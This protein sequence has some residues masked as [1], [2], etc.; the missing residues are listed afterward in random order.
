MRNTNKSL[1]GDIGI[2]AEMGCGPQRLAGHTCGPE[3]VPLV[4]LL[5]R[6]LLRN[7]KLAGRRAALWRFVSYG[8]NHT[9]AGKTEQPKLKNSVVIPTLPIGRFAC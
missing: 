7:R 6:R 4:L 3:A 2:P 5:R 8:T 9:D 1:V